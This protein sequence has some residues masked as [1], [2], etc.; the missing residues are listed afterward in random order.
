MVGA[1]NI[2]LTENILARNQGSIWPE[3]L[4]PKVRK[5]KARRGIKYATCGDTYLAACTGYYATTGFQSVRR[6]YESMR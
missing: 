5:C 3:I 4:L 6:R 2:A 1:Y